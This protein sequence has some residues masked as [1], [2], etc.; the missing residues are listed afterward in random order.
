[1]DEDLELMPERTY[2]PKTR[3]CLMC[4][5]PFESSWA[6]ERVCRRCKGRDGWRQGTSLA[7]DYEVGRRL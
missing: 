2:T 3:P 1:M 6:G 4:R 7:S 5:D